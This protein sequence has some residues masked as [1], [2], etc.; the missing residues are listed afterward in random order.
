MDKTALHSARITSKERFY[1][2]MLA[3]ALPVMA[4]NLISSLVNLID[5]VMVGKLGE[6][7][8]A[9]VGIANQYF[10]FFNMF[11]VGLSAGCSVLIAQ[12]WGQR[13]IA[14]IRRILGL[15]L[16]SAIIVATW[17]VIVGFL[18][19]E[20]IMALFSQ[21]Q[22][23]IELGAKYLRMV[24]AGYLFTG[25]TFVYSF[26]FRSIGQ[27]A[28]PMV[29]SLFALITNAFLNYVFIFGHFGAP[30][31]GVA[32]AALATM[33][34]RLLEAALLVGL[35][36]GTK[37]ALAASPEE[38]LDFNFDFVKKA[39]RTITPV[40]LNDIFWGTASLVYV[41][42]YA[43]MGTQDVAAVQICNTVNNLFQVAIFGL[44]GAASVMIG[45][46]IGAK[47]EERAKKYARKFTVLTVEVSVVLG[48]LLAASS[49]LILNFYNVSETVRHNAQ[50]I[51]LIIA[52]VFFIR[53]LSIVLIVGVLRGGGDV[54]YA[55][56]LESLTMWLVGVPLTVAGAFLFR[57]PIYLVYA[58][59]IVEELV[60]SLFGLGRL[61]SGQ[62]MKNVTQ[63]F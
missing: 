40:I 6:V 27:P 33:I 35:V 23:V 58:M 26:A 1:P 52:L 61:K 55:F 45:N 32:G 12:F 54:S 11:L 9:A 36:Y 62:W 18:F 42:V 46:S 14:N 28:Q 37:G 3:I 24:L 8:I 39:Y 7:E 19:P 31:M 47:E 41:A 56:I 34:A 53:G 44:S 17:F 29:I 10:F 38:L 63:A 30:A 25:L 21:D 51:L 2:A 15:G 4:Q 16:V 43:R 13:D 59:A 50:L 49:P 57:W 48:G 60:K 5:T 20:Q 22:L